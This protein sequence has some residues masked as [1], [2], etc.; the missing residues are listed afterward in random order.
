[1][2]LIDTLPAAE[3]PELVD[4]IVWEGA[5]AGRS[6]VEALR[7]GLL[8]RPDAACEDVQRAVAVC[9]DYLAPEGSPEGHAAALRA[10]PALE[11][12]LSADDRP[13]KPA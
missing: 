6:A 1:M 4:L 7:T 9:D 12:I 5:H 8:A 2:D 11:S 10:W 13:G 3:V